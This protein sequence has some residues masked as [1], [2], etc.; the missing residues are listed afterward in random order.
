V[1]PALL[2]VSHWGPAPPVFAPDMERGRVR[3]VRQSDLRS[4]DIAEAGGL[5]TTMHLDQ[6][7]FA[8]RRD[9][10]AVLLRRGGNVAFNGHILRVFADGL[11]LF[12][13]LP[14][15]RLPE[16]TL[17]QLHPH[18]VLAEIDRS[19][20]L[21]RH[22]VAGFYGR[23]YNPLPRGAV[24]VTGIGPE[25]LPIDWDWPTP[26]G[27]SIFSHAGNDLWSLADGETAR[28]IA[29]RMVSWCRGELA[30]DAAG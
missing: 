25:K 12:R 3:V 2:I 28:A 17:T 11:G 9:E 14:S 26:L 20:M 5:I 27:G 13:P 10:I 6:V 23:G 1:R 24:A 16:L 8:N 7:D 4:R 15:A 21:L 19:E 18:P 30:M 29:A 22:G